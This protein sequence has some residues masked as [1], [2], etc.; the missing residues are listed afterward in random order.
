MEWELITS[1]PFLHKLFHVTDVSLGLSTH[2]Q[3]KKGYTD[4]SNQQ[5]VHLISFVQ[6]AYSVAPH[7]RLYPLE[8]NFST[9]RI[10]SDTGP[11]GGH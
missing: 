3:K 5:K 4:T 11:K 9:S 8:D 2:T 1:F 10:F 6:P 7:M